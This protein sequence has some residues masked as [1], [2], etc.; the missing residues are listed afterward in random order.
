MK[1]AEYSEEFLS[2]C[3]RVFIEMLSREAAEIRQAES[4][5]HFHQ[6]ALPPRQLLIS[7]LD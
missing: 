2:P 4:G 1:K 6:I 5:M 3:L 7:S